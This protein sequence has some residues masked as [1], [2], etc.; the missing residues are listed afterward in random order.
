MKIISVCCAAV[1]AA[2]LAVG[3]DRAHEATSNAGPDRTSLPGTPEQGNVAK[4]DN[5]P[6]PSNFWGAAASGGMAEVELG[7]L[8]STKAENTEVKQFAQMMIA[9]HTK[10]NE[11][12]KTLASQKNI[13]IPGELD[14]KHQF[15]MQR[16]QGLSGAE[17]DRAYI[18]AM[19][20][21][22][23]ETIRLFQGQANGGIDADA[24]SF[25]TKTLPT[26]QK[27]LETARGIQGK[28]Q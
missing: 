27:H 18:D 9:D 24:K 5:E 4:S 21:D 15:T 10:T 11:E 13:A 25:A 16:L 6:K 19:V 22:H 26:L 28:M 2:A 8:A 14:P 23:E 7:K 1:L 20:R 3:C 12:L 17:F